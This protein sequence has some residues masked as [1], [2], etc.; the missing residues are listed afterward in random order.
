MFLITFFFGPVPDAAAYQTCPCPM[1]SCPKNGLTGPLTGESKRSNISSIAKESVPLPPVASLAL[2]L[3]PTSATGPPSPARGSAGMPPPPSPA[4]ATYQSGATPKIETNE[5]NSSEKPVKKARVGKA[6]VRN[7]IAAAAAAA[8]TMLLMCHPPVENVK[9]EVESPKETTV[10]EEVQK[11]EPSSPEL[12]KNVVPPCDSTTVVCKQC[13]VIQEPAIQLKSEE[14]ELTPSSPAPVD[15]EVQKKHNRDIA[16]DNEPCVATVAEN[17][18]VKNMKRKVES[19]K[20]SESTYLPPKR[21]KVEKN[22]TVNGSY[23]NLIKKNTNY[24]K[25]N[26]GKRKLAVNSAKES[27]TK[28]KSKTRKTQKRKLSPVKEETVQKRLKTQTKPLA[29]SNLHNS[30]QNSKESKDKVV[31]EAELTENKEPT[32]KTKKT[33]TNVKSTVDDRTSGNCAVE[34]L[35]VRTYKCKGKVGRKGSST[36]CAKVEK[37]ECA[38]TKR[39]YNKKNN[40]NQVIPQAVTKP[41]RSLQCPRWSNGWMWEGE[42]YEAKVFINVSILF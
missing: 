9:R 6:M 23:K 30:K 34:D 40:N 5:E 11:K 7:N 14:K 27:P 21:Q 37:A 42:P 41:R 39:K 2:P 19:L 31:C 13:E 16:A 20:E 8:N 28:N 36:K 29:A 24:V 18:K 32:K 10:L 35:S 25:I 4:G 1:Q 26:N 38:V 33:S 12:L 3:E 17:V 22:K 15:E